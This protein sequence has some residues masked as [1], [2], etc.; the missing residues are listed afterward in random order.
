MERELAEWIRNMRRVGVPVETHMVEHEGSTTFKR[1][2]ADQITTAGEPKFQFSWG[3]RTAFY[4]RH[5]F[6]QRRVTANNAESRMNAATAA[7]VEQFHLDMRCLQLRKP[8]V[9]PRHVQSGCG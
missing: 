1:L 2:H 8:T 4:K 7:G 5:D 6:S 9:D 3:W